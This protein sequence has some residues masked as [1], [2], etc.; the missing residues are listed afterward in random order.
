M[1][2]SLTDYTAQNLVH[3]TYACYMNITSILRTQ[4]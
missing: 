2:S 3:V 4:L 1:I